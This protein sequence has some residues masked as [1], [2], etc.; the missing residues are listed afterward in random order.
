M[1]SSSISVRSGSGSDL[2]KRQ[3]DPARSDA[4]SVVGLVVRLGVGSGLGLVL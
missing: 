4:E 1:A 3:G 2:C